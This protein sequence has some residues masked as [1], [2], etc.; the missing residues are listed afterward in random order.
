MGKKLI[1][2]FEG[3][4]P[5]MSN[6]SGESA[7]FLDWD[8]IDVT[9]D[10]GPWRDGSSSHQNIS[11]DHS[12]YLNEAIMDGYFLSGAKTANDFRKLEGMSL[13]E[14][15]YPFLWDAKNMESSF[16]KDSNSEANEEN[17][18]FGNSRILAYHRLG[19]I[20]KIL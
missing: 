16:Q 17:Y 12:Y 2:H 7:A 9:Q 10:F 4:E 18:A 5:P 13:G 8:D 20:I 14:K 1:E 6:T 19:E 11:I 3:I 15:H